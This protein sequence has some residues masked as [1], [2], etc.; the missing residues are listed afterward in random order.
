MCSKVV[1]HKKQ[2]DFF[3]KILTSGRL[4]HSYIFSGISGIGKKLF[5]RELARSILCSKGSFFSECDCQNCMHVKSGTYADLYEYD[6]K[7]LKIENIRAISESAGMTG[8]FGRWKIFILDAVER[9]SNGANIVAGNAFLKTLEEP[10]EDCLFILITSKYDIILP[11][12]RSRCSVINFSP[13]S[14]NEVK[15][16]AGFY[17][18][19]ISDEIVNLSAGSI[20]RAFLIDDL[21]LFNI[22]EDINNKDFK[23]FAWYILN[24]D[25]ILVFKAAIE[26]LYPYALQEYK[27][28]GK[29]IY[30][31]YGEYILEILR[32]LNYNVNMDLAKH[33]FVSK[34][35]EVFGERI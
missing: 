10:G 24:I 7:E 16:V 20:E 32:S 23:K 3:K 6:G 31:R 28:S 18:R 33:D 27:S 34:T 22:L 1:G 29:G 12:I 21:K 30:I 15:E 8:L 25:D 17:N 4:S 11:T 9:L 13:L 14:D 35:I 26:F 2:K 5:A 19:S